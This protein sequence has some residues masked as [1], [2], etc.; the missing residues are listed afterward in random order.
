MC[1]ICGIFTPGRP[2]D[3]DLLERMNEALVHRGPDDRGI[4]IGDGI[5]LAMRRL[6]IIDLTGGAQPMANEDGTIHVVHNG[7]VFNFQELREELLTKGH[8]FRSRSDTEVLVHAYETWG[9][10]M[11]VHLS[12]MYAFALWDAPRRR[13]LLAR[14]RAGKKP[15]Y[16]APVE[17]GWIFASEPK[18]LLAHP[19]VSRGVDPGA[20]IRYLVARYVPSPHAIVPNVR[21]LAPAGL[22]VLEPDRPPKHETYW[23]LSGAPFQGTLQQ[24]RERFEL[25]LTQAVRR[26][27]VSDVPLGVFLSG[28]ID[29]ACV[30]A[31]V[32]SVSEA[33]MHAFSIGFTDPSF[34]ESSMAA[35]VARHLGAEHHVMI[36]D[37]PKMIGLIPE[38]FGA[39]DE[40]FAD[41]SVLPTYLLSKFTRGSVT[42][43]LSGDGGDELFAGYP[44]FVADAWA[45]R[46]A[47]L[48]RWARAAGGGMADLLPV[49]HEYFNLGFKAR[50][51]WRGL[52]PD[53][54]W[55]HHRWLCAFTPEELLELLPWPE[56]VAAVQDQI[57]D[58]IRE[59]DACLGGS[60]DETFH[61][62]FRTYLTDDILFKVD[63]ASMA[64]SL[65]V[66][67]PLLDD[68]LIEF[69]HSL[70]PEHKLDGAIGKL[71]L[72][73]TFKRRLPE[74]VFRRRKQGF[75][76]PMARW[77]AGELLPMARDLLSEARLK[78]QGL[79]NPGVVAR[80]LD[81][82]AA[83]RRDHAMKL[84][85]LMAFE[86]WC[87]RWGPR[88]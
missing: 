75:A 78:A 59:P 1:G 69:A 68:E 35:R 67:S 47:W 27:L 11:M 86:L 70:P 41:A 54:P 19:G 55:R 43:A 5:G 37:P 88:G 39:L 52:V 83:R 85:T 24:A 46:L 26:R 40:P 61:Y 23:R 65:E 18:A 45:R 31:K 79:F 3:R 60:V 15:L 49:S 7:E 74:D 76:V 14:D 58:E 84:W 29:S 48:P 53:A 63:R 21:K 81:E 38:L 71:L 34:D 73:E 82:H 6:S 12:G 56:T 28:G 33:P 9:D 8:V 16:W 80:L 87:E 42:V 64:A 13:L 2:I 44:T 36:L 32:R 22:M 62:Y 72:R 4:F 10:G 17:G 57:D 20:L 51:F 50:Q 25:V 77:L 30:A 66:R